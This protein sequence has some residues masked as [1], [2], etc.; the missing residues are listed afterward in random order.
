MDI[1]PVCLVINTFVVQKNADSRRVKV[2][3]CELKIWTDDDVE[4]VRTLT[5]PGIQ[6]PRSA[7]LAGQVEKRNRFRRHVVIWRGQQP[8]QP[9]IEKTLGS[10]RTVTDLEFVVEEIHFQLGARHRG[11][12]RR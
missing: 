7:L 5:S 8:T 11:S 6:R 4:G 1:Y 9:I 2:S 10:G 12:S 3:N